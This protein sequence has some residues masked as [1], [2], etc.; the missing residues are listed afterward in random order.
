MSSTSP[1]TLYSR[2]TI[3]GHPLHAML[4]A[5]PVALYASSFVTFCAYLATRDPFWWRTAIIS[6]AAGVVLALIAAV[7]GFVDWA[8]GIP[9]KTAAKQTG[10]KHM[11]LNMSALALFAINLFVQRHTFGAYTELTGAPI[12][13][14]VLTGMG[15]LL[16]LGAGWLGWRLVQTHHVGIKLS[17]EQMRYENTAPA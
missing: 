6:N 12:A 7:P 10:A 16:T 9:R 1:K 4:V 14:V 2:V 11:I 5:F 15:L 13:A 8:R 17:A 3:G